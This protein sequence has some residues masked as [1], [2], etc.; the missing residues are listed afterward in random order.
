[1]IP[2]MRLGQ[3]SSYQSCQSLGTNIADEIGRC[4]GNFADE[5][6]SFQTIPTA[7]DQVVDIVIDR[8]HIHASQCISQILF[9]YTLAA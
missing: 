9:C 8:T 6:G 7:V 1:M 5:L 3:I 4:R 2:A